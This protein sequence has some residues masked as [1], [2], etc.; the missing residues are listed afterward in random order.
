MAT[1]LNLPSAWIYRLTG[2]QDFGYDRWGNR[3]ITSATGTGINN[4]QF[5][6]IEANNR[7]GVPLG[8]SGT[9][10]LD[11]AGNVT[12]DTYSGAK[13][14]RAY[15]ADNPM[16]SETQTAGFV[17]S[18]YL[19]TLRASGC[20]ARLA[21]RRLGRSYGIDGELL[22]EYGEAG[23]VTSPQKEYGYRNGA[24]ARDSEPNAGNHAVQGCR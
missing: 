8:Q 4:K 16:V 3:T 14:T 18:A 22:A 6:V 9:M 20:V 24:V 12:T 23:A 10:T 11:D 21:L 7:L 19:T 13:V 17:A 1:A 5:A 2:S 15:D